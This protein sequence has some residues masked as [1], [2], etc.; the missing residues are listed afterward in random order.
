MVCKDKGNNLQTTLYRK[1]SDQ[2]SYRQTKSEHH[3]AYVSHTLSNIL[4]VVRKNWHILQINPEFRNVFVNK[5]TIAFKWIERNKNMQNLKG[6]HLKRWKSCQK[7]IRKT[8]QGKSRTCNTTRLALYCMQVVNTNTFRGIQTKS[9]FNI[10]HTIA[11]KS[12]WIIYWLECILCNIQY[13]VSQ[14]PVLTSLN[15]HWED[16]SNPKAIPVCVYFIK[17]G[18]NFIQCAKFNRATNRNGKC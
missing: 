10:Y 4:E 5:P 12:Q 6:G 15:N 3:S 18:H 17:E 7:E 2:Q 1:P 13:V 9:V 11:C 14:K 8:R 16:V